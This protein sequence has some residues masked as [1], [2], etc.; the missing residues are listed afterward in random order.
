M[1]S[2]AF[3]NLVAHRRR[4]V[5]TFLAAVLGVAFLAG[6]LVLGDTLK[7]NFDSLFAEANAGVDVAVRSSTLIKGGNG[8]DELEQRGLVD[9][10]V[11]DRVRAVRGVANVVP[12]A[13]GYGQILGADGDAVGGNGP[14]RLAG[15]WVSDPA[16]N[17]YKLVEGRAPRAADEVVINQGAADDGHLRVGDRTIVQTPEPVPVRIVG[18]ATFGDEPGLGG[19]TYAAFTFEGAQRHLLG[20]TDRVSDIL[21]RAEPGVS[22]ATLA[23]RVRAVLPSGTEALTG[24]QYTK[25]A[26]KAADFLTFFRTF[27]TVFAAIA[28]LVAAFSIYNTF[29]IVV[30]QRTRESALLR[31]IGASRR[32]L[33]STV[34]AE[35]V[36]VGVIS[37]IA[38]FLAGIGIAGLL[39]GVFDSFGFALPA[40]GLVISGTAIAV[41]LTVGIVVT[42][43]AG[44]APALRASRVAPVAALQE[45]T[46]EAAPVSKRRVA[47]AVGVLAVGLALIAVGIAG[48]G[49][50]AL[51]ITGLGGVLVLA[52]AVAA[53]PLVAAPAARVL[54]AP[55]ARL[56]GVTGALARD[57][58]TRNPRRTAST[59]SALVVG[60]AI[61]TLFTVFAASLKQQIDD[62]VSSS[63]AGD[64]VV[65]TPSFGGGALSPN[66]AVDVAKVPDVATAVGV[67][68]AAATVDGQGTA[69]TIANPQP[70]A[71]VLD[72]DVVQGSLGSL[73]PNE[74]AVSKARADKHDWHV[75]SPV[76]VGFPDRSQVHTRIGAIYQETDLV[77]GVLVPR[78]TYTPHAVQATDTMVLVDVRN[79]VSVDHAQAEIQR[80]V[81]T[82]GDPDVQDRK[83]YIAS[84]SGG[85]DLFLGIVY[86]LLALAIVIAL[87]GIANTLSLA[88]YE[89]TREV[90]LLRAVGET[91]RQVRSMIRWE[92][93]IIAVFGTALGLGVGV[94]VAWA[95]ITASGGGVTTFA[96]PVGR[97]VVVLAVGAVVGVLAALR[98]AR[99]AARLDVMQAIATA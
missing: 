20:G 8:P 19:V 13:T 60:I 5:G 1:T 30:A 96:A 9:A 85:A 11:V 3:K 33:L 27:L 84:V 23:S 75:G 37:S 51:G 90:G 91:R 34:L 87:M 92:S 2:L 98:P 24:V 52:G 97:L 36:S 32:Q 43:V 41:S 6:T 57:N 58:A 17:P 42:V 63:F 18:I 26:N 79:G 15:N 68:R 50:G 83:E 28:L 78:V 77:G 67:G 31:A 55:I 82:Y 35:A 14:P 86:V 99:R 12:E 71:Q 46:V 22:Q 70:L 49:T 39:K 25:D 76:T 73:G 65:N 80:A 66:V 21:V 48:S 16:L 61:V 40:G 72:L 81:R 62:S 74:I 59:A 95:V 64:L 88:V 93:V 89:R 29:A 10:S 94:F 47:S 69:I 56:R 53:G 54:G 4:F 7:R 38:G 44:V 45:T